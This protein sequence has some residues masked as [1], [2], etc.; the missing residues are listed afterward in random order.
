[1]FNLENIDK[2]SQSYWP[3]QNLSI[4]Y[5]LFAFDTEIFYLNYLFSFLSINN[6]VIHLFKKTV[7]GTKINKYIVS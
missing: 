1:M 7:F 3:F 5:R 6:I 2:V 4:L